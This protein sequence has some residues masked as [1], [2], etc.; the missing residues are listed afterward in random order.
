MRYHAWLLCVLNMGM[1]L[2]GFGFGWC[3]CCCCVIVHWAS[4]HVLCC[5]AHSGL[6]H[7]QKKAALEASLGGLRPISIT[8]SICPQECYWMS[9][10]ISTSVTAMLVCCRQVR[11]QAW[12]PEPGPFVSLVG[13]GAGES[14]GLNR[15]WNWSQLQ[16]AV[17]G[18]RLE[19]VPECSWSS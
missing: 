3:C 18:D 2:F 6:F 10:S 14:W 8:L 17:E 11:S 19:K 12:T 1:F 13:S 5:A 15:S 4:G 7:S 9:R 16:E